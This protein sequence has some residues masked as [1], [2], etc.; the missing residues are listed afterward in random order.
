MLEILLMLLIKLRNTI[1][2]KNWNGSKINILIYESNS[3]RVKILKEILSKKL[4]TN[5]QIHFVSKKLDFLALSENADVIYTYGMS[6]YANTSRLKLLFLG[7]VGNDNIKNSGNFK[8]VHSSNF[9]S[10]YMSDY[11]VA[12]VFAFERQLL[13]NAFLR[14]NQKWDQNL[15]IEKKPKSLNELKIG[16]LGLGNVGNKAANAFLRFGCEVFV[17]DVDHDK[18]IGFSN[19]FSEKNWPE[20]LSFVDY[21]VITVSDKNSINMI[22]QEI[23]R[24]M[25]T[26]LCLVNVSRASV[27][28]ENA[29]IKLLKEKRIRGA[30]LDV[31]NQEPLKR[32][33]IY[34]KL[35]NVVVTPHIAGNIN[36]VFLQIANHFVDEIKNTI[37]V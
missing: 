16:I 29:F 31:F 30:I 37:N 24:R 22:N 7:L 11:I 32:T 15:Y 5:Y 36:L 34:W 21:F 17:C 2:V 1:S 35:E 9:A 20:M 6:K 23:F 25:N 14:A 33:S 13:Q 28:D 8:I 19:C 10:S 18:M 3:I 12:S 26:N 27:M 4:E